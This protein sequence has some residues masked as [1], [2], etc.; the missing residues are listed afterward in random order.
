MKESKNAVVHGVITQVKKSKKDESVKYF[1][2]QVSDGKDSVR[3]IV[4]ILV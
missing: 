1:S 3:V 2:G 4:S